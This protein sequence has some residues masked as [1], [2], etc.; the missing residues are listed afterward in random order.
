MMSYMV[1]SKVA[2]FVGV[3]VGAG[4]YV[5][6]PGGIVESPIS[7]DWLGMVILCWET[8]A[9]PLG[10]DYGVMELCVDVYW[11]GSLV[12]YLGIGMVL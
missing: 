3:A 1:M 4:G 11:D 9:G 10:K 5:G 8:F 6:A 2:V 12:I 7:L